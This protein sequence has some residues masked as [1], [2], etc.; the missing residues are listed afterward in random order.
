MG[1]FDSLRAFFGFETRADPKAD[2]EFVVEAGAEAPLLTAIIGDTTLTRK[3]VL[4]IPTV[5]AALGLIKGALR[6]TPIKLYEYGEDGRINEVRGDRRVF[7]LNDDP[8]DTLSATQFWD[9][10][11]EDYFLPGGGYA[12]IN[13][14]GNEIKSLHYVENFNISILQND[15]P[16]FKSYDILIRGKR[17][18]PYQFLKILRDTKDGASGIGIVQENQMLLSTAYNTLKF[19]KNLVSTG[20]NKKGFITAMKHL[21]DKAM[22]QLKK[23]WRKLYSSSEENVVILNDGLTF[24]ECS[25]TSV[26]M[27]LNENKQTNAAEIGKL[28]NIPLGMLSGTGTSAASEDDKAKFLD[29]CILPFFKTM[30]N[31]LNRDLLLESEKG[32]RFFDF[33]TKDIRKG[34]LLERYQAYQ[35]AIRT[36]VMNVDECRKIENLPPIGQNFINLGLGS[37]MYNPKTGKAIVPNTG[38]ILEMDELLKGKERKVVKKENES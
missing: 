21:T 17:Y 20:G 13:W 14:Q 30:T 16:I 10:M 33:D 7:L 11:I 8:G 4:E 28:F 24:K 12:Y 6:E 35:I 32:K 38:E 25:N 22:E 9:A 3:R 31:A 36:N 5:K 37:V 18:K 2:G 15:D 1:V 23:A 19:E 29:Y 27:Q 26:E 34:S